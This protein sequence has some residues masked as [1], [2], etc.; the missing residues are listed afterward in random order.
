MKVVVAD[1]YSSDTQPGSSS[2]Y[3]AAI[4]HTMTADSNTLSYRAFGAVRDLVVVQIRHPALQSNERFTSGQ[5]S[6]IHFKL[7]HLPHCG[8]PNQVLQSQGQSK[9]TA[10]T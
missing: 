10:C 8:P 2:E 4:N 6:H 3:V 1:M 7:I 5:A 9:L